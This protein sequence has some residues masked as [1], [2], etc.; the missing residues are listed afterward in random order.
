M[1]IMPVTNHERAEWSRLA[2]DAYKHG[3]THV[4]HRFSVAAT[5]AEMP[6]ARFDSLQRDY[7]IWL[8]DGFEKVW[9][10]YP[11]GETT[12]QNMGATEADIY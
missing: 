6:L 8:L 4:G 11:D 2:Q 10:N 1:Q 7:R 3:W 9:D 5:L 12:A